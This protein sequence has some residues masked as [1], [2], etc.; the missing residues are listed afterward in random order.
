MNHVC[1]K[2]FSPSKCHF[3]KKNKEAQPR[4]RK[5]EVLISTPKVQIKSM[6]VSGQR[7]LMTVSNLQ[8][9]VVHRC[10]ETTLK[11][12]WTSFNNAKNFVRHSKTITA[13][14]ET[15]SE[16]SLP[17][18]MTISKQQTRLKTWW[19][20]PKP[21]E[22]LSLDLFKSVALSTNMDAATYQSITL[23]QRWPVWMYMRQSV[24]TRS[25]VAGLERE[26]KVQSQLKSAASNP[27]IPTNC[28]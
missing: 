9:W 7:W 22:T 13:T 2:I 5:I 18:K 4:K 23:D 21:L 24:T 11:E 10:I 27:R 3:S 19:Q 1:S 16:L 20:E 12:T 28:R 8:Y 26:M 14:L 6:R 17:N 25:E 15:R